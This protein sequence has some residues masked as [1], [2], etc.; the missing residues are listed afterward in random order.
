MNFQPLKYVY[1]A[2][3]NLEAST[4]LLLHGTGGDEKD[5]LPLAKNFGNHFNILSVRGNVTEQGM[6]RFFRR[7]GLGIFDEKDLKFRTDELISF[8]GDTANK[9]GF[10]STKVIA[11]GYSNGANI[12]GSMLVHYPNFLLGAILFRPMLPYKIM[13]EFKTDKLVKVF[14]SCG[15]SDTMVTTS[16]I[17]DYMILL[18]KGNFN[19]E[20]NTL[21][22]G[23]NLTEEDIELAV[24]WMSIF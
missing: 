1:K 22:T 4:L 5:L 19:V 10:D 23:H 12:A 6:P 13:P 24:K 3:E 20:L 9:E 18:E 7:I 11:L 16:E 21:N 8:I 17:Q 2:A 15:K 14:V